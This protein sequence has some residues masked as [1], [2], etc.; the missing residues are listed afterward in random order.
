MPELPRIEPVAEP[1]RS[2]AAVLVLHGGRSRS[3]ESGEHRRL[4]YWRMV[5]FARALARSGLAT[6][7]LRYRYRGWNAPAQDALHDAR[8]AVAELRRREP[9]RSIVLLGHSMGGRAA[10]AAAGGDGVAAVC[11]LA[12]WLDGSD[13]VDQLAG[14]TVLI[15]HGDRERYT[16]PA[17]SFAYALRAKT[18]GVRVC[19]FELPGAGHFLIGRAGDW[20]TLVLRFV[21]GATGVGPEDPVIASALAQPAPDGLRRILEDGAAP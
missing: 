12:P 14:R 15:A 1:P 3:T 8:W 21:L 16:D 11:A 17:E 13:P 10:L 2:P 20:N 4:T 7:L 9:A 18:A 19:R 6:Y 5:P